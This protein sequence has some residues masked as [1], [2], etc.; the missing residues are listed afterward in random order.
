[1]KPNE[2][3]ICIYI[4]FALLLHWCKTKARV[5][6]F[7][8]LPGMFLLSQV[9]EILVARRNILNG[10]SLSHDQV[11]LDIGRDVDGGC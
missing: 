4:N 1:M 6:Q 10:Y 9:Y 3:M 8:Q 2:L 11:V 7:S 5:S